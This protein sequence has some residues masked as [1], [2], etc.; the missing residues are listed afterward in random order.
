MRVGPGTRTTHRARSSP[1]PARRRSGSRTA[2]QARTAPP[3]CAPAEQHR[4]RCRGGRGRPRPA[5]RRDELRPPVDLQEPAQHSRVRNDPACH[6]AHE[7]QLRSGA[8]PAPRAAER[9]ARPRERPRQQRGD[10]FVVV[11]V[12]LPDRRPLN[13]CAHR[14]GCIVRSSPSASPARPSAARTAGSTAAARTPAAPGRPGARRVGRS[15]RRTGRRACR[16]SP[17]AEGRP[18]WF[19]VS[20]SRP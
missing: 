9:R 2:S 4:G 20:R 3:R 16:R 19:T 15:G 7:P 12:V 18:H 1:P 11:D 14:A 5:R 8:R 10:P 17:D 6:A 13:C